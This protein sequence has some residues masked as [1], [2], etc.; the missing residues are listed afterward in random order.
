MILKEN[1]SSCISLKGRIIGCCNFIKITD[2]TPHDIGGYVVQLLSK[3]PYL[4]NY[5]FLYSVNGINN[6]LIDT[7]PTSQDLI[8]ID[9]ITLNL[10]NLKILRLDRYGL[11]GHNAIK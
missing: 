7:R 1:S 5:Q 3:H 4:Q 10:G 11:R 9:D 8:I 2:L 6:T